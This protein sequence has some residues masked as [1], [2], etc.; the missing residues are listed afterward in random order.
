MGF[1]TQEYSKLPTSTQEYPTR[2]LSIP[3]TAIAVMVLAMLSGVRPT[4]AVQSI[5]AAGRVSDVTL[6]RGQAQITRTIEIPAGVEEYELVVTGLP[7]AALPDS[8][9]AQGSEG[10]EVRAVRYRSRAVGKEPREEVRK[11]DEEIRRIEDEILVAADQLQVIEQKLA[12]LARLGEFVVA[13]STADVSKGVLEPDALERMTQFSFAENEKSVERRVELR[14]RHRDLTEALELQRRLRAEIARDSMKEVREAVV[15]F[16]KRAAGAD[17]IRLS[18]VVTNCGWSPSYNL[19]ANGSFDR[20][21]VEYNA[22]VSQLTGEDWKD[23][24]LTLSTATPALSSAGPGLAPFRLALIAGAQGNVTDFSGNQLADQLRSISSQQ[25]QAQISNF[26]A[27]GR[28]QSLESAW[29]ANTAAAACQILEV[30]E[31]LE[32]L[33]KVRSELAASMEEPSISYT[34]SSTV[35]LASRQEQQ[36]VRIADVEL[37]AS[38]YHVATPVLGGYVYR[39]AALR[40]SSELDL[41]SGPVSAFLEHRFVGRTEIG[42]VARGQTFVVGFGADPQV[43]ATREILRRDTTVQGGNQVST[44]AYRLSIENYKGSAIDVRLFDRV[45]YSN[46]DA[47]LRVTLS[48]MSDE[49]SKDPNFL[50]IDRARGILRWDL[51]IAPGAAGD[52]SRVVTYTYRL[53]HDR[54]RVLSLPGAEAE[55]REEFQSLIEKRAKY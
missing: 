8:L 26:T 37:E 39:E 23:V 7:V 42:T 22:L 16:L 40:N 12:Y 24:Q 2:R 14:R 49:L 17:T 15:Y 38:F 10:V 48:E 51:E 6:Y 35:G 41:L 30:N 43:R 3:W 18:Y 21:R 54:S 55:Q 44:F 20:A 19:R 53:E 36:I 29:S 31:P 47:E 32:A 1:S 28:A 4:L 11:I 52:T 34:L 25:Q 45:P 50:R 46:D 27:V 13:S 9:F 33:T 5:E